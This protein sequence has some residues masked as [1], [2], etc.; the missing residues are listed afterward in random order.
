M[1]GMGGMGNPFG[2]GAPAG[3]PGGGGMNMQDLLS[4]VIDLLIVPAVPSPRR[5]FQ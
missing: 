5:V 2:G 4:K 3:A 1:G